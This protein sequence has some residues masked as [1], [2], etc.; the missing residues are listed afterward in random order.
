MK[1]RCQ[2]C[3]TPYAEGTGVD[4]FCCA[5]CRQVYALIQDEGLEDFYRWQDRAAQP[6]KD[7]ALAEVDAATFRL[8]QQQV[9]QQNEH[10]KGVAE[11]A[12]EDTAEA[13][14]EAAAQ[15]SFHV[16][17]MSCMGCAWLIERL[18]ANQPGLLP[19]EASLS[20]YSLRLQWRGSEFDLAALASE[21]LR[22]G[23]RLDAKPVNEFEAARVSPLALRLIL[24]A[25]FAGNALLL[26]AY[27]GLVASGDG[28]ES[29]VG[30][31]SLGCLSFSL[32][33]GGAPFFM[34]GYRAAQIR[35]WHSDWLAV[36]LIGLFGLFA[37]SLGLIYGAAL[38]SWFV[39][40]LIFARWLATSQFKRVG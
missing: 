26:A 36:A 15:A 19:A 6:L 38:T 23:Y 16:E 1:H 40:L 13:A 35:R 9:E 4:G 34:S 25:L 20:T 11:G 5:G 3:A 10:P 8:V 29:L 18:C 17:G 27:Q 14:A 30:L 24:T 21:L 33:L 2:H 37:F 32:I 31:L 22:F 7:R 28:I 39:L 12:A